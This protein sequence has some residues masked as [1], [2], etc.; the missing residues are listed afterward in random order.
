MRE[1]PQLFTSSLW[2]PGC[3]HLAG[4]PELGWQEGIGVKNREKETCY[5]LKRKNGRPQVAA[6]SCNI[7]TQTLMQPRCVQSVVFKVWPPAQ[8]INTTRELVRNAHSQAPTDSPDFNKVPRYLW[9]MV[10]L[11]KHWHMGSV[12]LA[13]PPQVGTTRNRWPH[14]TPLR[15]WRWNTHSQR[16]APW[17]FL[18]PDQA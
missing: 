7:K 16:I 3:A 13:V 14:M 9:C 5:T 1:C 10:N 12:P 18:A 4:A 11:E 6:W 15:D 17:F 8:S 2:G